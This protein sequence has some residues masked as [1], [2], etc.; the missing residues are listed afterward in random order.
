MGSE[1]ERK[2]VMWEVGSG[3]CE[4]AEW[5]VGRREGGKRD[6]SRERKFRNVFSCFEENVMLGRT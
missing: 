4:G 5:E 1:E 6:G 2:G 3:S